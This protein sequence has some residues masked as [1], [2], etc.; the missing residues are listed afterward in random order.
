MRWTFF[1]HAGATVK[2]L[3]TP[4]LPGSSDSRRAVSDGTSAARESN[5][6][7]SRPRGVATGVNGYVTAL[8]GFTLGVY[9]NVGLHDQTAAIQSLRAPPNVGVGPQS[10]VQA[11]RA[12]ETD[13]RN[14]QADPANHPSRGPPGLAP[15]ASHP[16]R[17]GSRKLHGRVRWQEQKRRPEDRRNSRWNQD[18]TPRGEPACIALQRCADW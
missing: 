15:N 17:Y 10:D 11:L 16:P 13:G 4:I 7:Q 3:L 8:C 5:L 1:S 2:S 18:V 9:T 12:T 14:D 6:R